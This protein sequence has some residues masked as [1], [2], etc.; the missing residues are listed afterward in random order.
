[1]NTFTFDGV[2][3][4]NYGVI[5]SGT[6][7]FVA[8]ERDVEYLQ[9]P[10]RNGTLLLDNGRWHD[11]D[12]VYPCILLDSFKDSFPMFSAWLMS[13][14]G[15]FV[16]SD[17]YDP[18]H[19]RRAS[20]NGPLSPETAIAMTAGRFDVAFRCQPQKYLNSGNR[21]QAVALSGDKI[22]NPTNYD[23]LPYIEVTLEDS[24][25]GTVTVGGQTVTITDAD[26]ATIYLDCEGQNAVMMS[27]SLPVSQNS[28]I[29]L[30]T[31]E[32]PSIKPGKSI[33]SWT[34]DVTGVRI[35]PRWWTL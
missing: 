6:R 4:A 3:S 5:V 17:T 1:M 10:G 11:V 32:F 14:V 16:L 23:S 21:Y 20:F 13:K 25:S 22:T 31:G 12:I 24:N 7:T 29:E 33:V 18:T 28:K 9:V 15:K 30:T 26:A 27:G 19:F 34:G 2:S 35:M 8:P